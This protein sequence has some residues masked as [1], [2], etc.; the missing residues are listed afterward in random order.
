[1]YYGGKGVTQNYETA[2]KWYKLA[3]KQGLAKAQNHLE[4]L[5]KKFSHYRVRNSAAS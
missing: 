4:R 5:Q 3:A 1:M 2:I